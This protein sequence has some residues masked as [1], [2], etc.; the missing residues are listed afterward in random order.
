MSQDV[1]RLWAIVGEF[2][3][4]A[5][6]NLKLVEKAIRRFLETEW[7]W[8]EDASRKANA[9]VDAILPH[10]E[11]WLPD[12]DRRDRALCAG[13]SYRRLLDR[14][15]PHK[16]LDAKIAY[17]ARLHDVVVAT[18]SDPDGRESRRPL[19]PSLDGTDEVVWTLLILPEEI[20]GIRADLKEKGTHRAIEYYDAIRDK[21]PLPDEAGQKEGG[22]QAAVP[23][24]SEGERTVF[25]IIRA[26]PSGG[27]IGLKELAAQSG[28]GQ[29]S[30]T[31]HIIPRLK[32]YHS[33]KNRR[34]VGY[35]IG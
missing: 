29:S 3:T 4:R 33:V 17:L 35:H 9:S 22:G 20:D 11:P 18:D 8:I 25:D 27:A 26:L 10:L 1:D 30:L 16:T 7:A 12:E 15:A 23:P 19:V 6:A 32:K 14:R 21:L 5:R 2:G 28:I 34:N 31:R 13:H 24:L